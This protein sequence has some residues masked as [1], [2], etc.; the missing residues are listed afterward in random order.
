[1][2]FGGRYLLTAPRL[3]VWAA[4]NDAETLRAAI[5]GCSKISWTSDTELEAIITVNLGVVK[6]TF[7][8][9]LVLSDIEP[10]VK[11]TLAGKGR[12][13][14]LG[15]A[16][17]TANITLDD[18]A[19]G[20]LLAFTADGGASGQIMRLGRA[21][22]GASAQKIIDHFFERFGDAMGTSVTPLH[23]D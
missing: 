1:M 20:T 11:Y 5:P 18:H 4:L 2:E 14:L 13:G 19:D 8:G 15:L 3:A 9:D 7:K 23:E 21:I 22:V 10:A 16:H 17:G 6:P 12:G